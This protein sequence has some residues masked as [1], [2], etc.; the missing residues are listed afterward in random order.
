MQAID[1]KLQQNIL[2]LFKKNG[3]FDKFWINNEVQF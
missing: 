1:T 3:D 2:H